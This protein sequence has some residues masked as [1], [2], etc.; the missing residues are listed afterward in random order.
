MNA[1]PP[2]WGQEIDIL[3][4]GQ[5]T[6]DSVPSPLAPVCR[7]MGI[8][9]ERGKLLSST[10]GDEAVMADYNLIK[11]GNNSIQMKGGLQR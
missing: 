3:F 1:K 4:L 10:E 8:G 6:S 9:R 11:K 5:I 2:S 7:S